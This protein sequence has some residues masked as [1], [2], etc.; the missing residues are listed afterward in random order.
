MEVAL[1]TW[2]DRPSSRPSPHW[3]AIDIDLDGRP[4]S[5][6]KSLDNSIL[7]GT[8]GAAEWKT[9][10]KRGVRSLGSFQ[11]TSFSGPRLF[12]QKDARPGSERQGRV[13][14][15]RKLREPQTDC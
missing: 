9:R 1:E 3:I 11:S 7:D 2:L 13:Q 5:K 10:L 12:P 14:R 6:R 15:C 4:A 8:C